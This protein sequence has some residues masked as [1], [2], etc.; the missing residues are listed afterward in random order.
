MTRLLKTPIIGC[1]V[2]PVD[3]SRI[4][5]LAGLSRCDS[6]RIPPAFCANAGALAATTVSNALVK[7]VIKSFNGIVPLALFVE[8]DVSS[9]IAIENAIDHQ[10]QP[11]T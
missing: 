3:S 11:L 2:A 8:P 1:N 10:R 6:L 4:D 5:M 7:V 9:A